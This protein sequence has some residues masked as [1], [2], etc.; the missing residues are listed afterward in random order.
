MT[1]NRYKSV[2]QHASNDLEMRD[3]GYFFSLLYRGSTE[4]CGG[5]AT[6]KKDTGGGVK[7]IRRTMDKDMYLGLRKHS[8]F[9]EIVDMFSVSAANLGDAVRYGSTLKVPY[10]LV[11]VVSIDVNCNRSSHRALP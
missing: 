9:R 4:E 11:N 3:I 5:E 6:A 10:L 7:K 2:L 1:V 8:E